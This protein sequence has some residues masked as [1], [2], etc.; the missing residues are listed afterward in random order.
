MPGVLELIARPTSRMPL[1]Y[2]ESCPGSPASLVVLRRMLTASCPEI[3]VELCDI[4]AATAP[5]KKGADAEV[6][7][8]SVTISPG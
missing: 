4:T 6:P 3:L 1:P 7:E 8:K 2:F 5:E